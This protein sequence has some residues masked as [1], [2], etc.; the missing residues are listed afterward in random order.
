[1]LS[2][3]TPSEVAYAMSGL[4]QA[5]VAFLWW[6]G[7]RVI[8]DTQR[9]MLNWSVSGVFGALG[10]AAYLAAWAVPVTPYGTG[11]RIAG[12]AL[13]VLWLIAL[14]RGV[15]LYMNRPM[16]YR[17]HVVAL[18]ALLPGSWLGLFDA[19]SVLRIVGYTAVQAGLGVAI[20]LN[21][22]HCARVHLQWRR[23]ALLAL[24]MWVFVA[25]T[26]ARGIGAA[27]AS[28]AVLAQLI[29]TSGYNVA[30]AFVYVLLL[31]PFN[32]VLLT[33]VVSR[34]RANL[35]RLSHHDALT[36]LLNRRAFEE[37]LAT[38]LQRSRRNVERFCV[39]MLDVD[40]FKRI[41]DRFGHAVGDTALKH[42]ATVLPERVRSVDRLARVGGEEFVVL[43]PGQV[44]SDAVQVGERL[45]ALVAGSPLRNAGVLIPMTVSIGIAEWGGAL[46]DSSRLLV[47][48]DAALYR[49]KHQGRN[50]IAVADAQA[51]MAA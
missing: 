14:Q 47:R 45:R 50:Q 17:S 48:A 44:L 41:N 18:A 16:R 9:V 33:L 43:L 23:P 37:N 42:L 12:N 2:S 32:G 24:P 5:M 1:M 38:Q 29:G 19:S 49:A 20:A 28:P 46:E 35:Q 13:G 6:V 22:S 51:L 27:L 39:L 36:G 34:L 30:A 4:M 15:W 26:A 25:Y 21:L 3:F 7:A 10:F 31:L 40:H 11:F 8:G